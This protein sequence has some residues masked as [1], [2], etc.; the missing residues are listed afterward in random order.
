M[1]KIFLVYLVIFGIIWLSV[2]GYRS[3]TKNQKKL[4][5]KVVFMGIIY[6]V[7][8]GIILTSIVVLF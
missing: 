5:I 1:I 4:L 3:L 7:I 2:N 8:T 6:S